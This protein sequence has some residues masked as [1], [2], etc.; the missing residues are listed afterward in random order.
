MPLPRSKLALNRNTH[1]KNAAT[2]DITKKVTDLANVCEKHKV[3]ELEF[4]TCI[5]VTADG[6]VTDVEHEEIK[7]NMRSGIFIV[8]ANSLDPMGDDVYDLVQIEKAKKE[9]DLEKHNEELQKAK[10]EIDRLK[11]NMEQFDKSKVPDADNEHQ[12]LLSKLVNESSVTQDIVAEV[13]D[14]IEVDVVSQPEPIVP[15]PSPTPTEPPASG[16][17]NDKTI[18]EVAPTN[19]EGKEGDDKPDISNKKIKQANKNR[20]K[21]EKALRQL[22][23]QLMRKE[24]PKPE[25]NKFYRNFMKDLR[26]KFTLEPQDK[27]KF[28]EVKKDTTLMVVDG[29]MVYKIV[30]PAKT[31]ETYLLVVGDLD[32]KSRLIRR[33]DPNYKSEKVF[34]EQNEF[35]ERIK[36]KENAKIKAVP[37]D[38]IDE[39]FDELD[40]LG[41]SDSDDDGLEI[42]PPPDNQTEI[43]KS[44]LDPALEKEITE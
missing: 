29:T 6:H 22:N 24:N 9:R 26:A 4:K 37:E 31:K 1:I 36:A 30:M 32:M 44:L 14:K 40:E 19:S 39:E 35:L 23:D 28:M 20:N 21:R 34:Q 13:N 25:R 5:L 15:I 7:G 16:E 42:I 2:K 41:F 38:L 43:V 3:S 11:N 27:F 12:K 10:P 17:L 18:V 33:I 8:K